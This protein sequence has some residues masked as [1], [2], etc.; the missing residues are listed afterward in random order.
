MGLR[1]A[2]VIAAR[3]G[4]DFA[5]SCPGMAS[6]AAFGRKLD[7]SE[8]QCKAPFGVSNCSYASRREKFHAIHS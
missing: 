8:V 5:G 1:E 6:A 7:A 3:V 2:G 4:V